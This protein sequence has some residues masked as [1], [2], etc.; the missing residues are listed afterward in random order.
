MKR[1]SVLLLSAGIAA[2][3]FLGSAPM[4][5]AQA[6]GA[7][8][9][10]AQNQGDAQPPPGYQAPPPGYPPPPGYQQAPPPGYQP[11][12]GYPPPPGYGQQPQPYYPPPP[13]PYYGQ[14][15]APRPYYPPPPP[16]ALVRH[17]LIFGVGIGFGGIG[18]TDCGNCGLGLAGELHLGGMV[19]PRFGLMYDVSSVWRPIDAASDL[20]QTI[21]TIAA[22][23][24]LTNRLWVKGGFGIGHITLRD[25]FNGDVTETA[26]AGLGAIGFEMA[27]SPWFALDLQFRLA[28]AGYDSGGATNGMALIGFNWY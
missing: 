1:S 6:Q 22:Q 4:A 5:S 20:T 13:P 11:P 3:C 10:N 18:A 8:A 14:P 7:A 25:D 16:P 17:G 21:H 12:P 15:Y 24:W 9:A 28:Y 23:L 27:Q 2:T 26:A 19:T